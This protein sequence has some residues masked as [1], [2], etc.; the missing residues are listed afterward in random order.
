M[1]PDHRGVP[2]AIHASA[3]AIAG[4]ALLIAG[5]SR[6]GKSRLAWALAAASATRLPIELVGDD[7]ILLAISGGRLVAR[8]HPRIAGFIERRGL[9]LVAVPWRAHAPVGGLVQL[10]GSADFAAAAFRNFPLLQL[11]SPEVDAGTV[12]AVLAWWL[13]AASKPHRATTIV[14]AG[15]CAEEDWNW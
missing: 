13:A 7:R 12:P 3:V 9:G 6:S 4:R 14:V 2:G 8:P 15:P 1:P 5:R 11:V 10:G